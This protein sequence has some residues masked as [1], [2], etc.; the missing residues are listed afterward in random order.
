MKAQSSL[1][2]LATLVA[3]LFLL[4]PLA[5]AAV[6]AESDSGKSAATGRAAAARDRMQ[7]TLAELN[8]TP[9]Q[10]EKL[11]PVIRAEM[12]KMA[13]LRGDQSLSPR[14]RL[15]RLK[16]IQEETVPQVKA[17]LTPEQFAKWENKRAE[18]REQL[19]ERARE[20]RR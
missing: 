5:N 3:G 8:L 14:E 7:A 2:L 16:A 12:Q 20:R 9:E 4:P 19:Q 11:A 13:A 10:K 6:A 1:P 15:Q 18:A 17:I